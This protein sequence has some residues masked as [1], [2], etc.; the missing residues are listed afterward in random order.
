MTWPNRSA[1]SV[2]RTRTHQFVRSYRSQA[3]A[4]SG[5]VKA[6]SER[7]RLIISSDIFSGF[8]HVSRVRG[9]VRTVRFCLAGFG[10]SLARLVE[11]L[12]HRISD[13]HVITVLRSGVFERTVQPEPAEVMG[14]VGHGFA[15]GGIET[16]DQPLEFLAPDDPAFRHLLHPY[17]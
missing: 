14:E 2:P 1:L 16:G 13:E 4:N 3:A 8:E 17:A 15:V 5:C 7:F 11:V 9:L 12:E 10:C 6:G